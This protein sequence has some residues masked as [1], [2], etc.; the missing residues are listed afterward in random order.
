MPRYIVAIDQGTT[1]S[2]CMIFDRQG[3][4]VAS[5]QKEHRQIYPHPGW[6]EHDPQEI[7]RCVQEVIANAVQQA[8]LNTR[9]IAA[10]GV[11]NQRET[12]VVWDRYSGE[13]VCNAIVW[14]DTRTADICKNL[15][16]VGGPDQL[17]RK[18]GL[19]LATYFS[20]PKLKWILE[21]DRDRATKAQAGEL[22]FG[23]IDSWLIWNLTGGTS[24]GLHVTDVTNA[25]RTNVDEPGDAAVGPGNPAAS[26]YS[27]SNVADDQ[28]FE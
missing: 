3:I 15:A 1:S 16:A 7:W 22:L 20:G 14:Q 24:G 13:P 4:V 25:S 8:K 19:P 6:V 21:N 9:D 10:V 28:I 5:A 11:T 27:A 17:R 26:G 2:R 18:V 12:V 23:T